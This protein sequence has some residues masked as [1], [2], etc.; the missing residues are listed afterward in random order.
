M[1]CLDIVRVII[2]PCSSHSFRVLVVRDHVV[3]IRE[4]FVADSAYP[5]LLDNLTV[6]KL[7]HL[8]RGPQFPISSRVM[9]IFDLW[10]P[11]LINLGLGTNSRP[12]QESDL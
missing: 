7:P 11:S 2:P 1:C 12:Q 4:V 6:Q 8:G 3:V 10:T 5:A 9:R